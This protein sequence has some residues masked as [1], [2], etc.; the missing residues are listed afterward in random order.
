MI[1]APRALAAGLT[2]AVT[3][4]VLTGCSKPQPTITVLSDSKARIVKAQPACTVLGSCQ[5]VAGRV[6]QVPATGGSQILLD[7][8]KDLADSGWIVAAFTSDGK[9]NTALTT[10]GAASQPIQG[11]HTVRLRVPAATS[12][13]YYLQVTALRPT[14]QLTT[15]LLGVELRQ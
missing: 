11:R 12:G 3:A 4:A 15:W 14:D 7:V 6:P 8:P 2:V 5:P 10:P 9:T 1:R 13:S